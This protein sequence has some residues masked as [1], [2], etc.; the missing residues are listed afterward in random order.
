MNQSASTASRWI[1]VGSS[2]KTDPVQAATEATQA[3]LLGTDPKLVVVFCA[4]SFP[5]E[6]LVG[7]VGALTRGVP[8]IGCTTAGEIT[9]NSAHD[10]SL[11]VCILG[12]DFT[13]TTGVAVSASDDLHA[14]GSTAAALES[15]ER[16]HEVLMLL[17]DGLAGNQQEVVHGAYAQ[18]GAGIRLVGGCAGDGAAMAKTYQFHDGRVFENAV[19]SALIGSDSPIGIG[20]QHGWRPKGEPMLVGRSQ[21]TTVFELDGR[22]AL[23]V[24]LE[25]AAV[26]LDLGRDE[27]TFTNFAMTHPLGLHRGGGEEVRFIN[28]ADFDSG[29]L[30]GIAEIPQ[31]SLV[32]LMEGD[33]AS[34]LEGTRASCEHALGELD[35]HDPIGLLLFDC[36]ARRMVL[37][38]AG[39]EA[40]MA[41]IGAVFPPVATAGF[42]T[43]G[44]IARTSGVRGFHNQTLVTLAFS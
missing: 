3:A 39:V 27:E 34:V 28:G 7:Q 37:G 13:A 23:D 30:N 36:I 12:G 16:P 10:D 40:E 11:T 6:R 31:G 15:S 22:R 24:Y 41:S 19:V 2:R 29:A 1:G 43:Y 18:I 33:R 26:P 44:E 21:G 25:R 9:T 14:A 32:W 5:L 8:M 4:I 42:Y 38:D 20:V 35:D 17:T